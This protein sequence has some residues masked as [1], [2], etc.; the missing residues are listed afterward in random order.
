MANSVTITLKVNDNA[1]GVLRGLQGIL[2]QNAIAGAAMGGAITGAINGAK[3]AVGGL[4]SALSEAADIQNSNIS[5]AGDFMKMTGKSYAESIGFV[6]AFT[7]RMAKLAASL[8]GQ[9]KDYVTLGKGLTDNLIPAFQNLDGTLQDASF[10]KSLDSITKNAALRVAN[11]DATTRQASL[12]ISKALSGSASV[13]GLSRLKFFQENPAVLSAI[14]KEAARLGTKLEKMTDRQRA[15][16][17][18]KALAVPDEVIKASQDSIKGL[19]EG[20]RSS[21]FDPQIGLFGLL[22]DTDIGL[23]GDQSVMAALS[24]T[25]MKVLG[26]GGLFAQIGETLKLLGLSTDPM[27]ALFRGVTRFNAWLDGFDASA[28]V[29][30]MT[31]FDSIGGMVAGAINAMSG[32]II[33]LLSNPGT[34][35]AM[36]RVAAAVTRELANVLV[37][38]DWKSWA[39]ISLAVLA[40]IATAAIGTAI[41]GAIASFISTALLA[42]VMSPVFASAAV[43]LLTAVTG[44]FAAIAAIPVGL[45]VLAVAAVGTLG[46][47]I[48]RRWD[49]ISAILGNFFSDLGQRILG[50]G[51]IALGVLTLNGDLIKQGMQNLVDGIVGWIN[52]MRDAWAVITGGTTTGQAAANQAEARSF[53]MLQ[54]AK[55]KKTPNAA[56]G[57]NFGGLFGALAREMAAMPSGASPV[58]A[59]SAET[60]LNPRQVAGLIAGIQ[61]LGRGGGAGGGMTIGNITINAGATTDPQALAQQVM[62]EIEREWQRFSNS[63][64]SPAY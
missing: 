21:L 6:D 32:G 52:S 10:A 47:I 59:N 48:W 15:E 31:S 56:T 16:V 17:I 53:E 11:T 22:R 8:P 44:F 62:A 36:G 19:V 7:K 29:S 14:E 3:A 33:S 26:P 55:N 2:G 60:I 12:A 18:E 34:W 35:A 23:S 38:L 5:T 39:L 51:Q 13:K 49:E 30:M 9:T 27:A 37:G 57:L 40:P 61:G 1:S 43:G 50:V 64:L 25:A 45:I 46:V 4:T 42:A 54:R 28:L 58:V 41:T 63:K 24:V 20:F